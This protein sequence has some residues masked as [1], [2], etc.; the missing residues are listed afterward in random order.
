MRNYIIEVEGKKG[1]ASWNYS[2]PILLYAFVFNR[3]SCLIYNG[4]RPILASPGLRNTLAPSTEAPRRFPSDTT[5]TSVT[6]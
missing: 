5:V 6:S 4:I 1:S 2:C 3:T